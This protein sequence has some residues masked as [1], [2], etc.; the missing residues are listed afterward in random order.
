MDNR[1]ENPIPLSR[2]TVRTAAT[3]LC[4][5]AVDHPALLL[6]AEAWTAAEAMFLALGEVLA[7]GEAARADATRR[8]Q[9]IDSSHQSAATPSSG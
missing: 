2:E 5:Y 4:L 1:G 3:V 7:L 6:G 9:R 8:Q